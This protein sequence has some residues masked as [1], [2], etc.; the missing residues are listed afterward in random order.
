LEIGVSK[1]VYSAGENVKIA[2]ALTQNNIG[3]PG[4]EV[5]IVVFDSSNRIIFVDE[6]ITDNNGEFL[7]EFTLSESAERGIYLVRA[8]HENLRAEISFQVKA[9]CIE[10]WVCSDWS[11]CTNG[12]Q[13][14]TCTDQNSCGTTVK[15]PETS[16]TCVIASTTQTNAGGGGA[17]IQIN[18]TIAGTN[19]TA[20]VQQGN[21]TEETKVIPQENKTKGEVEVVRNPENNTATNQSEGQSESIG[22]KKSEGPG[23]GLTGF[24]ASNAVTAALVIVFIA[25]LFALWIIFRKIMEM[26]KVLR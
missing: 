18:K 20:N 8:A 23:F 5:G 1:S 13:T 12:V 17:T 11:A 3:V 10:N 25:L 26:E 21:Q 24:L 19:T 14:R 6:R 16:Q 15:K 4:K 7:T 2:G 22:S 9:V